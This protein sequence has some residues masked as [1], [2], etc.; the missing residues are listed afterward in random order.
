VSVGFFVDCSSHL[1]LCV[2]IIGGLVNKLKFRG[3]PLQD[4]SLIPAAK[5]VLLTR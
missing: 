5:E 2:I 4:I 3:Y 1:S